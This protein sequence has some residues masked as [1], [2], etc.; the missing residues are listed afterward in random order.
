MWAFLYVVVRRK[1]GIHGVFDRCHG[2]RVEE[3]EAVKDFEPVEQAFC[4][5]G[6]KMSPEAIV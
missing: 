3:F 2:E 6:F 1:K 4:A 5:Q